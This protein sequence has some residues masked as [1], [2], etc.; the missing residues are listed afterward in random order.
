MKRPIR[1]SP[2]SKLICG[3]TFYFGNYAPPP[4]IPGFRVVANRKEVLQVFQGDKC[5]YAG[6]YEQAGRLTGWR[7]F[8]KV[9]RL[10]R[11]D[12]AIFIP[13][14]PSVDN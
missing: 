5:F 10:V 11:L 9:D 3:P 13:V 8:P 14:P 2:N 7:L 4:V 1:Q 12:R 6:P